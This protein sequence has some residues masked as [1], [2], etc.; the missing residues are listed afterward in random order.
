MRSDRT[1]SRCQ[2]LLLRCG[3]LLILSLQGC[4]QV[5]QTTGIEVQ[6][7][8]LHEADFSQTPEDNPAGRTFTTPAGLEASLD[9]AYL[10]LSSLELLPC[11][12]SRAT[13]EWQRLR[14]VALAHGQS[15]PVLLA[16]PFV[17]GLERPDEA[18]A[19]LGVL[20]PPP[21][22]YCGLKL[23]LS[24]ADA[25]A[26]G[27]TLA[28]GLEGQTLRLAGR[29]QD[30][31]SAPPTELQLST[32]LEGSTFLPFPSPLVLA[33]ADDSAR[34]ILQL[35]YDQW[36]DALPAVTGGDPDLLAITLLDTILNACSLEL[37]GP[38]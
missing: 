26:A 38:P 18:P 22:Q 32:A 12:V 8:V 29:W 13:T 35:H 14:G 1:G 37:V 28:S 27:L 4:T 16:S 6:L 23:T 25:D 10:V 20:R 17:N 2:H 15:S 33:E 36:L 24:P 19:R 9:H 3:G 31:P 30:S 21:G 34:L 5:E 7:E 11:M